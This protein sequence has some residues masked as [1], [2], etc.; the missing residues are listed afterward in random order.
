MIILNS[1]L[2]RAEELEPGMR[3]SAPVISDTGK[4]LLG[5][6]LSLTDKYIR[7]LIKWR[8]SSVKIELPCNSRLSRRRF[9]KIYEKTLDSVATAFEKIRVFKEVPLKECEELV[10]NYIH[11]MTNVTDVISILHSVK[12]HNE[13][14]FGHSLN[15]AIIAGVIGKW[16]G[17]TGK[18]LKEII[19][20]GLLHDIGK[21]LINP[22]ILDKSAKLTDEEMKIIKTHPAR[23]NRLVCDCNE[24]SQGV[25]LAILQHHERQDGSGYP[26]RLKGDEIHI[27]ANIVAV[28]DVYDAMSRKRVYRCQLP[29]FVIIETI[30][31]QM[32]EKLNPRICFVFLEKIR[33][34]MIGSLVLLT[35]GR[36]GKIILLNDLLGRRPVVQLETGDLIDLEINRQLEIVEVLDD[37]TSA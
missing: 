14:T 12:S 10:E 35:D 24:I 6:G 17:F 29:P 20:A 11:L 2:M 4:I 28:A 9:V 19:L 1:G 3:L 36:Q 21:I 26:Q 27:Y 18:N 22:A 25:K 30:R 15:V 31:E 7:K 23:G 32:Y 37:A 33:R 34:Y 5:T 16:L 8:A 13:Y